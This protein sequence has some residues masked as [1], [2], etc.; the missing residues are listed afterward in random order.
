MFENV[1]DEKER[2][3]KHTLLPVCAAIDTGVIALDYEYDPRG[4]ETVTV[5]YKRHDGNGKEIID[6][7]KINVTADSLRCI[8]LDV[9][10]YL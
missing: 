8:V 3:V 2:F 10:R 1:Y 6:T 4:Q 5:I 7:R 9:V